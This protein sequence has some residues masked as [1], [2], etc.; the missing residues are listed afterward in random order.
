MNIKF[1]NA[2]VLAGAAA[3]L[4]LSTAGCTST[5]SGTPSPAPSTSTAP[6]ADVF[7]GLNACQILDQLNA[8][9]GF[10]PGENKSARNQCVALKPDFAS[11]AL[12]LDSA[13]GL[14]EFA[15][16]NTGVETISINGRDAMQAVTSTAGCA[17][18]IGVGEHARALVVVTMVRASEDAQRCPNAR[19]LAERVEPL[20]P[21]G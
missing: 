14:A 5:V 8:G 13:Q 15:T 12:A 11:Y 4:A 17:V 10:N 19:A 1:R 3:C 2:S 20:L 7:A 6:S 9:Q 21:A 18:A 16:T